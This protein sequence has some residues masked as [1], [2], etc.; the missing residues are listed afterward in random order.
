VLGDTR[1]NKIL[2]VFCNAF[3]NQIAILQVTYL[4]GVIIK[5]FSLYGFQHTERWTDA[6]GY[7]DSK[8]IS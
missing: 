8:V 1:P 7:T 5:L 4:L 3:K 6:G 2:L